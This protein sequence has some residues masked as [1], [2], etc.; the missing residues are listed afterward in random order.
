MYGKVQPGSY[1]KPY[2]IALRDSANKPGCE[3]LLHDAH[4]CVC[5]D[6]WRW[7]ASRVVRFR[8]T[9]RKVVVYDEEGGGL[10]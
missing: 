3:Y 1:Q 2:Q 6:W 7:M 9:M 8:S 5:V 10:F 4:Q